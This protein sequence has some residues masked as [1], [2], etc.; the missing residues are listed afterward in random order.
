MCSERVTKRAKS[1]TRSEGFWHARWESYLQGQRQRQT[2]IETLV[3][4]DR[5]RDRDR[6]HTLARG[7][8]SPRR[9]QAH[10]HEP[11]QNDSTCCSF[12]S[13]AEACRRYLLQNDCWWWF[14]DTQYS[15]LLT[16]NAACRRDFDKDLLSLSLSRSSLFTPD[17]APNRERRLRP[18]RDGTEVDEQR[19]KL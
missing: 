14:L 19:P 8:L 7:R 13:R 17:A 16:L 18:Q 9:C 2:K 4:K 1:T 11:M 5:D 3:E 6:K 15:I 12:L 10:L